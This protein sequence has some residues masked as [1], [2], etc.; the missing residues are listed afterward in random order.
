MASL[1]VR[2]PTS[3]SEPQPDDSTGLD[4]ELA[5]ARVELAFDL[6]GDAITQAERFAEGVAS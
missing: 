2:A 5:E 4:L 6:L 3:T 1:P